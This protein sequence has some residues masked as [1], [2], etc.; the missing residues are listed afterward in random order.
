MEVLAQIKDVLVSLGIYDPIVIGLNIFIP[1]MAMV[2]LF[3]RM[4]NLAK[5]NEVKNGIAAFTGFVSTALY[6]TM[7]E[8]PLF[9]QIWNIYWIGCVVILLYVL[10]GFTLFSRIDTLFDKIAADKPEKQIKEKPAK[11]PRGKTIAK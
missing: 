1:T 6:L 3:G 7:K 8:V 4:L 10:V 5:T 11:K 2:Y 9:I